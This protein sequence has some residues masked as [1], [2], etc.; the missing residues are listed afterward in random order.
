M[1]A[2]RELKKAEAEARNKRTPLKRRRQWRL[3][4]QKTS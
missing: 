3:K 2:V 4:H 1:R